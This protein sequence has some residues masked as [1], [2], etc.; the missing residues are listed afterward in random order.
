MS[1]P[2]TLRMERRSA[3]RS[4]TAMAICGIVCVMAIAVVAVWFNWPG[5][6]A[7]SVPTTEV[8]PMSLIG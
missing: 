1:K 4:M 5:D 7:L 2:Q 8:D 6:I 3:A